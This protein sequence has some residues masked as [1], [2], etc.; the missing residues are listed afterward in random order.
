M[1]KA[2]IYSPGNP[3]K[4]NPNWFTGKTSMKDISGTIHSEQH[5]IY[6]VYFKG[7]SKTKLHIH[8]GNQILIA[9]KGKGKLEL[10]KKLQNKKSHFAIKKIEST[11]LNEGDKYTFQ[12]TRFTRTAL[13]V[14]PRPFPTLPSISYHP[15]AQNTK[16]YG[17][18]LIM[19][20]PQAASYH[21][22][23]QSIHH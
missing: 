9:T 4:I 2:N 13:L 18:N 20:N 3:R 19:P 10:Y 23:I 17:M 22:K 14:N 11:P 7:G 16:P 21:K 12:K 1:R 8:N 6:H 5:N 15:K